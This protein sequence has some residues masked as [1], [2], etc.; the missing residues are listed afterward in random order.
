MYS[1]EEVYAALCSRHGVR[2]QEKISQAKVAVLG[3]GGLGSHICMALARLGVG[4]ILIA[5]FDTVDITNIFRQNY[6]LSDIGSYK[7]DAIIKHMNE[8][9]PY[10]NIK[11]A[12][13]KVTA[14]NIAELIR[15]YDIICEAFDNK[16]TKSVII[17]EILE[18]YDDK[19]IVS[20]NGMAGYKSLNLIK[21]RC[22]GKRLY[23][24]GDMEHGI[25]T[26][27]TLVAPRVCA[28]AMHEANMVLQIILG[29][30][31]MKE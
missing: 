7:T 24:C 11:A 23:I 26:E 21:T 17:N 6:V 13:V 8:T 14:Q 16:E 2:N 20:G 19:I 4:N 25:E 28:C 18:Q 27:K 30:I 15:D 5:D 12:N 1:E 29:E 31:D 3:L 9:N 22:F 10:L